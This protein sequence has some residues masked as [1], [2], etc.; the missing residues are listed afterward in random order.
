MGRPH[1]LE[2][3]ALLAA[4][5]WAWLLYAFVLPITGAWV[6]FPQAIAIALLLAIAM[7]RRP[8][9]NWRPLWPI[10]VLY[11]LHLIALAW[12]TDREAGLTDVQV[13]L[14]L[15]LLPIAMAALL[16]FRPNALREGM[17]AFTLGCIAAFALSLLKAWRCQSEGGA[18]CFAQSA[19]SYDVHPSYAAWYACWCIAYWGRELIH[20]AVGGA[21]GRAAAIAGVGALAVFTVML[22]SKS[23]LLAL[24]LVG[25]WL[26]GLVLLRMRGRAR[27]A[28][29]GGAA[30]IAAVALWQGGAV[31]WGRLA[32]ARDAIALARADDMA[33][34]QSAD[35]NALRLVAWA[36][37]ADLMRGAP[38]GVGPGDAR[39]A[40]TDCYAAKGAA[41]A[42]ERRLN[43]HSQ[44][45]QE[46][47]G[48]GWPGLLLGAALALAPLAWALREKRALATIFALML[49]LNMAVESVFEL[50]AGV[51]F[52]GMMLG[53]LAHAGKEPAA[54]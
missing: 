13:K 11:A 7:R 19:L 54:S 14:G 39:A 1:P 17:A 48:L 8:A 12:T 40:L 50:Q 28:A 27:A 16:A 43:S 45:M 26:G 6:P 3:P 51:A 42:L 29:I 31:A 2:H 30:A 5:R 46:G 10:A 18:G 33:L 25:L 52:A 34:L 44:L 35:G 47:V 41:P 49:L 36:C 37:S 4:A 21:S 53:L 15:A 9:I 20:G 22:A 32:A 38:F 24:G 23:G